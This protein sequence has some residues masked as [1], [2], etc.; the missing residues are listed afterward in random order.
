[1]ILELAGG[2][3]LLLYGLHLA[4]EG[5]QAVAGTRLRYILA[6]ITKNRILGLGAGALITAILQSSS[7]T[8]VM[9]VGFTGSG[10]LTLRQ[11]MAVILGADIG[12]TVTVQL[13]A[14]PI[15]RYALGIV[16]LGFLLFFFGRDRRTKTIG[17]AILGFGLIFL[18]LRSISSGMAPLADVPQVGG[19]WCRWATIP[20]SASPSP[21]G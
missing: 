2:V 6:S 14:F 3:S 13:L 21:R 17:T 7:A 8:T 4:G 18:G 15:F 20:S 11:T 1:M 5:L 19:C 16:A 12:T 9:L 10:L